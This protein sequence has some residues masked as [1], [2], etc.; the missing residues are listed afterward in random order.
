MS[1]TATALLINSVLGCRIEILI[2]ICTD[3]NKEKVIFFCTGNHSLHI[4]RT[5]DHILDHSK[6]LDVCHLPHLHR[7]RHRHHH[8]CCRKRCKFHINRN[9]YFLSFNTNRCLN[10]MDE[11]KRE[12]ITLSCQLLQCLTLLTPMVFCLIFVT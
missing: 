8:H 4:C 5:H 1:S 7:R 12:T 11:A 2:V 9:D 6:N 3:Y 10:K